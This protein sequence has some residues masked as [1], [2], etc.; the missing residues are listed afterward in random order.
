MLTIF[1]LDMSTRAV[2][3]ANGIGSTAKSPVVNTSVMRGKGAS[4][5]AVAGLGN[6]FSLG[7][8]TGTALVIS[9]VNVGARRVTVGKGGGVSMALSSSA[10]TLSRII[11][12]NCN[13]TGQGSVA[14]SITAIDSRMLDTIPMTS[15]AR[16]LRNGVTNMRVAAARNSPST[17]VG[18]HMHN[19]NSVANSGAPLFVMSNF[20][21]RSVDSVPTSSVRSVAMLGSTS[22]AT[23]CNSHNTGNMVLMAAGDKG[24]KGL[25]M[26]CGACCS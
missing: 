7:I 12:V 2:A 15:T 5:N 13:A 3:T 8:P 6:S 14:N 25:D 24:R 21:M 9:C 16:T 19:N 26:S 17:R 4:G 22:S 20:P 10:G 11:I 18:V 23:V 1:S